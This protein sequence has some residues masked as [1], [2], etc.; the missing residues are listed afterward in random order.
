MPPRSQ[1]PSRSSTGG[2]NRAAGDRSSPTSASGNSTNANRTP[3]SSR[4]PA[5]GRLS[6]AAAPR[7]G[8]SKYKREYEPELE[9]D[10]GFD[11]VNELTRG[12]FNA[13]IAL[14]HLDEASAQDPDRIQRYFRKLVSK[15]IQ[16]A[17]L[18]RIPHEDAQE[19]A[20]AIVALADEVALNGPAALS[21]FWMANLLQMH[22]FDENAAGEGFFEHLD[23]LRGARRYDILKVYYLCLML[24]FVGRYAMHG[25]EAELSDIAAAV[26]DTLGRDGLGEPETLSPQGERPKEAIIERPK[27][28]R[29]MWIPLGAVAT[30]ALLYVI[31][32]A[33]IAHR[34][35]S[36]VEFFTT[37]VK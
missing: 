14:R 7:R 13:I 12:C 24:G 6:A 5:P 33:T 3:A 1:P 8:P 35:E 28:A 16:D 31:L 18:L 4:R 36:L 32:A 19:M 23:Q 2:A 27:T 30:A 11:N 21:Q 17:P 25:N 9:V 10:F 34:A 20:Y 26:R 22:F 29:L 37:L 15:M